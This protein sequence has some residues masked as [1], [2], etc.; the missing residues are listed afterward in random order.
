MKKYTLIL[1]CL[2]SFTFLHAQ[3]DTLY[4]NG[5]WKF[6]VDKN[7]DGFKDSW[8]SKELPSARSVQLPHTWNVEEENQHHYG[9]GWYQK[10]ISAPASWK[11]KEIWLQFGA[12]NHTSHIYCNG[13]LIY[14][15]IGDGYS[16]FLVPISDHLK[17]G[18]ENTITV[19]VTNEFGR[20]KVPFTNS[21]DWPNDGGL[22]RKVALIVTGKPAAA[23]VKL[24]P[25]Y[26]LADSTGN[27]SLA[28]GYI[29]RP[30][31]AIRLHVVLREE[32]QVSLNKILDTT[33]SPSWT[34][35]EAGL[36][37]ALG[38]VNAWHFDHPN[39]YRC[40]ITVLS[41]NKPVD[42]ISAVTGFRDFRFYNGKT[43]L[44]GERVKL[45]GVEWTAG[46]NPNLGLAEPDTAILRYAGLMKE[47]NAI[48]TRQ[49]FQ[50]DELF[51]DFCDRKG[52]LIQ[53]E[54]PLW[55]PDTPSSDSIRSISFLQLERMIRN[56][57][58]HPSVFSWGVG[59]E[60]RGRDADMKGFIGDMLAYCRST[61]PT[62]MTAY[63]SNTLTWGFSNNP[64]FVPDAAA[65][66]DYLM[67]NEYGGSWW[68]LP[69]GKIHMYLDSVHMSYP[70]KPFFISEFGLCEPNFK[71][72]D[73]RR[74]EDLIYHMSIYET[75]PYVEGAI[76]FDLTDYRTHMT[77]TPEPG[78]FRQRIHG[79]YDMYGKP[80]PSM[81][82][83]RE[84]SSPL[85]VQQAH[86]WKK[87]KIT[88]QLYGSVGLPQH[89][90]SG[91][92]L[93]W[94]ATADSWKSAKFYPIPNL[95]PGQQAYIEVDDLYGGKGVVTVIKPTGYVAT[96][97]SFY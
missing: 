74:I 45:M 62:R 28:L 55:G 32:N 26:K 86:Q 7:T 1:F 63:V 39:L 94:T 11:G 70:D 8:F 25:N 73:E 67:M 33:I 31:K 2:L 81:K 54:V 66:G 6:Q 72:G 40:D 76:Y 36:S 85:E 58:N 5:D 83:L 44:N 4:L 3:R 13:K 20:N 59:N 79:I 90:V 37:F 52:I 88:L 17:Y 60:L 47:V 29:R 64:A 56:Y 93:C 82:I 22:I 49:H 14:E 61:D 21:F 19:A 51:Y 15:N 10:K 24:T 34:G 12:V 65:N 38:K 80:K 92:Q 75:K 87:G 42:Q 71:G 9:W 23:Y 46:S 18:A 68:S 69:Q 41:Q 96:Q 95:L 35:A 43:Y 27:L 89:K 16:K 97:K 57:Y 77:G 50:Q 53:Q 48:Y 84:L 78:R 30:E 91:Y